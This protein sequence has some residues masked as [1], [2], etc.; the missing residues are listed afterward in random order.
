MKKKLPFCELCLRGRIGTT[1]VLF[2]Y[3]LYQSVISVISVS[4]ISVGD[5]NAVGDDAAFM[6]VDV[7]WKQCQNRAGWTIKVKIKM[8]DIWI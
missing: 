8:E 5:A 6:D 2:C 7:S 4:R 3:E 1:N